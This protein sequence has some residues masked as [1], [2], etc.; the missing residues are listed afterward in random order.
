MGGA[1][2]QPE[3]HGEFR[4]LPCRLYPHVDTPLCAAANDHAMI[5][6]SRSS[7]WRSWSSRCGT[8]T[9][10]STPRCGL[11]CAAPRSSE[12]LPC[13]Q[14][15]SRRDL[16][17]RL[18]EQ[19]QR[20]GT[21]EAELLSVEVPRQ[22]WGGEGGRKG[23]TGRHPVSLPVVLRSPHVSGGDRKRNKIWWR[24][25]S[26]RRMIIWRH[27]REEAPP[28]RAAVIPVVLRAGETDCRQRGISGASPCSRP[29]TESTR[30]PP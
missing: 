14:R 9:C 30:S 7:G 10:S 28:D 18:V 3:S 8:S 1:Q 21:L 23:R 26:G 12:A 19:T 15:R 20:S 2:L 6:S 24:A 16:E 13:L 4:S 17:E 25:D 5:G 22:G 11:P 29:D 27:R